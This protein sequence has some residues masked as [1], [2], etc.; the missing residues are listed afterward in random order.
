VV[1]LAPQLHAVLQLRDTL[2]YLRER[3]N[4]VPGDALAALARMPVSPLDR[5]AYALLGAMPNTWDY[6]RR[7]WVRYRLHTRSKRWW[8]TIP[9]FVRYLE[10]TLDRSSPQAVPAEIARRLLR[11]RR[12]RALGLR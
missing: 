1:A 6:L 5:R 10:V 12:D 7:P 9:G 4:P 8:S 11:W 2:G 3:G